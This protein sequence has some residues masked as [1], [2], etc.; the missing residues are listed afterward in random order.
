MLLLATPIV[1][2]EL[3]SQTWVYA[4]VR[5]KARRSL[6]LGKYLVAVVW[7]AFCT[8]TAAT[9]SIPI[10]GV[11]NSFQVWA[12]ICSLCWLSAIAYGALYMLI[13]TFIQRRAMVIAFAYTMMVEFLLSTIPAVISK[14]TISNRLWS[15]LNA[16]FDFPKRMLSDNF[17]NQESNPVMNIAILLLA[18]AAMLGIGL[19]R[20]QSTQFRWQSEAS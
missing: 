2:A 17:A 8:S 19:W 5:P 12:A 9:I 11:S 1:N 16:W 18:S 20:I 10:A 3:E 7:T 13:G 14:M 4:V 6:L 15:I